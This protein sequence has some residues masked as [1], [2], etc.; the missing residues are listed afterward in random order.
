MRQWSQAA[1]ARRTAISEVALALRIPERTAEQLIEE[2]RMLIER[3]P[4]TMAGLSAGDF[5]FR[6]A[7]S[8]VAHAQSLPDEQ[9]SAFEITVVP[10]ASRLT[11]S[12]FDE[13][14]RRVRGR[15]DASTIWMSRPSLSGTASHSPTAK[16]RS[17]PLATA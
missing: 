9:H 17:S 16:S 1:T 4:L 7:K 8:I 10:F 2:S 13:R 11:F 3:L 6:H 14:A 5:S 15:M 12:K